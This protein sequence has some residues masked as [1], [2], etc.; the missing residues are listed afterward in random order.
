MKSLTTRLEKMSEK[1]QFIG[2]AYA[3]RSPPLSNFK[4]DRPTL[5]RLDIFPD[6]QTVDKNNLH[7]IPLSIVII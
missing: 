1:T 6:S 4:N 2:I 5:S 3:L 7:C